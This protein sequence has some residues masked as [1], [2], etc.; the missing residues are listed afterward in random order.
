MDSKRDTEPNPFLKRLLSILDNPWS[1]VVSATI[2]LTIAL[3]QSW[4]DV[5]RSTIYKALAFVLG[6]S[7]LT[8]IMSFCAELFWKRSGNVLVIKRVISQV[9]FNSLDKSKL[10]PKPPKGD[11]NV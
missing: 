3:L 9:Y 7:L 1:T 4:E 10:N 5:D 2:G 11:S 8:G 6:L